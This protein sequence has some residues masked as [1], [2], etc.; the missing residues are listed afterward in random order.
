MGLCIALLN[1]SALYLPIVKERD[2]ADYW[3]VGGSAAAF[4]T[5]AVISKVYSIYTPWLHRLKQ[6]LAL[7]GIA[8]CIIHLVPLMLNQS[9][10]GGWALALIYSYYA[11]KRYPEL[12]HASR[13]RQA[14]L[15]FAFYLCAFSA[16]ATLLIKTGAILTSGPYLGL[17]N[18]VL[19]FAFAFCAYLSSTILRKNPFL[20]SSYLKD[21][22]W[23]GL[24]CTV[25]LG[26]L[27]AVCFRTQQLHYMGTV[28]HWKAILEPAI[29][30]RSGGWLLWDTPSQYGYLMTLLLAALPT[31]SVWQSLYLLNGTL[32]TASGFAIFALLYS[33]HRS[34]AGYCMALMVALCS[35]TFLTS[36]TMGDF[37]VF[38]ASG[39][40]RFA[41]IYII[42]GYALFL[43]H[44]HNRRRII[45]SSLYMYGCGAA[46]WVCGVL[47]SLE[48]LVYSTIL[49]IPIA[50][51]IVVARWR[52]HPS[53]L[54]NFWMNIS[55]IFAA[56]L[57]LLIFAISGIALYY[58]HYLD[59]W[60]DAALIS[61]YVTAYRNLDQTPILPDGSAFAIPIDP[62]GSV[63]CL[64]A[65]FFTICGLAYAYVKYCR[66]KTSD[67][68]NFSMLYGCISAIWAAGSYFTIRSHE[69][70]I[71]NLMPVVV[72]AVAIILVILPTL[73]LPAAFESNYK[74]FIACFFTVL[75]ISSYDAPYTRLDIAGGVPINTNILSIHPVSDVGLATLMDQAGISEESLVMAI[76]ENAFRGKPALTPWLLP[77]TITG[78]QTPLSPALYQQLAQR[79]AIRSCKDGWVI[80]NKSKP[81]EDYPWL[82]NAIMEYYKQVFVIENDQWR[83]HKFEKLADA[84]C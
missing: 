49:W 63:L 65:V 67:I 47:W 53:G 5:A 61:V 51:M 8:A 69:Q 40:L 72:Y 57:A 18:A 52:E 19:P 4:L 60:P 79:R 76:D 74:I 12:P 31:H 13:I 33:S 21:I 16:C 6:C 66:L 44:L 38:P 24:L 37:R 23:N 30:V 22:I 75:L 78:F 70:N 73:H 84:P 68:Y 41:W 20:E 50:L 2:W 35:I 42:L 34:I 9:V 26:V 64:L 62:Y 36:S 46:L 43:W 56:H 59:H 28:H 71:L 11:F 48:S 15:V 45:V 80:E 17:Q 55:K 77:N 81:L 32:L 39:I 10:I 27:V 83:I 29:S 7:Y 58:H 14:A 1:I 82:K 25:T 3:I 54:K